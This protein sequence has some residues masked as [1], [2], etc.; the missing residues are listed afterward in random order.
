MNIVDPRTCENALQRA[1]LGNR[2]AY[3][4]KNKGYVPLRRSWPELSD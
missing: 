1:G 2:L 3:Q 4:N